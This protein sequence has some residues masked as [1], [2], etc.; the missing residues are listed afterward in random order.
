M[1]PGRILRYGGERQLPS[2]VVV[3]NSDNS[4]PCV[5]KCR[6]STRY[7]CEAIP[8]YMT[9]APGRMSTF[10]AESDGFSSLD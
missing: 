4:R 5:V 10:A 8:S 3:D 2:M 1:T 9:A 6:T 7:F